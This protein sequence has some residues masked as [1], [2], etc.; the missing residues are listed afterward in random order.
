MEDEKVINA[1]WAKLTPEE[2][3]IIEN[4]V[5]RK[6][7]IMVLMYIK[8]L[9]ISEKYNPQQEGEF[10]LDAYDNL[11][12]AVGKWLGYY[13]Y[14]KERLPSWNDLAKA[15]ETHFKKVE[16]EMRK[17][18]WTITESEGGGKSYEFKPKGSENDSKQ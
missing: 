15:A 11:G 17:E 10:R 7:E 13:P 9:Q 3:V 16:D 1:A 18:G 5:V 8:D 12:M 6:V 14:A 2:Q 4:D